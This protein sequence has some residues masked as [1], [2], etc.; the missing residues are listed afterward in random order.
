VVALAAALSLPTTLSNGAPFPQRDVILFVT[1]CVIFVTL[2]FQG[3]TLPALIRRLGVIQQPMTKCEEVEARRIMIEAALST[4]EQSPERL[5]P[6]MKAIY[7]D[8]ASHYRVRLPNL[9]KGERRSKKHEHYEQL[10]RRLR[11]EERAAAIQ[12]RDQDRISDDVL[13][14][15]LR[16]LDLLDARKAGVPQRG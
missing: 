2:V 15:L 12:L 14:E 3:L 5:D 9:N 6:E 1:F 7:D 4:L 11:D 8:I 10:S 16:E 13:R